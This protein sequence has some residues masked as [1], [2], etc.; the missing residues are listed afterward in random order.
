MK[1]DGDY[2]TVGAESWHTMFYGQLAQQ[3]EREARLEARAAKQQA[4]RAARKEK[5][6]EQAAARLEREEAKAN[7]VHDPLDSKPKRKPRKKQAPKSERKKKE[8]DPTQ[9]IKSTA[10]RKSKSQKADGRATVPH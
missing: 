3:R 9:T 5:R 4:E 10:S 1:A 6:A 7:G 2:E 8:G